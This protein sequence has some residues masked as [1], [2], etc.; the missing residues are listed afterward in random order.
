MLE[1]FEVCSG[2]FHEFDYSKFKR[3]SPKERTAL[4][5]PAAEYVLNR[6]NGKERFMEAVTRLSKA[7]ALSV[8]HDKA[9][10]IR[11]DVGFFQTVRAALAKTT[12]TGIRPE[13]DLDAAVRQIVSRAV[14]SDQV[15]DIFSAAGLKTPDISILS[16]EFLAEVKDLPHRDLAFETLRRLLNDE[17]KAQARKNLIQSRRFSEMLEETIRKYQNRS[18]ETAQVIQELIDLAKGMREA[19]KRGEELGFTDT[20]TRQISRKRPR[21]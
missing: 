8:P 15:I 21:K 9:I 3:G 11:E 13:E 19:H 4:I 2:I 12:L 1:F 17:I 20:G 14:A 7:F 5:P 10:E 16:D 6:E 18:I